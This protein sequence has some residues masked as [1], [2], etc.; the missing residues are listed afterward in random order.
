MVCISLVRKYHNFLVQIVAQC[1]E[2]NEK[3]LRFQFFE[4][5]L[6]LFTIFNQIFGHFLWASQKTRNVLNQIFVFFSFFVRFRGCAGRSL[7]PIFFY[8]SECI[9]GVKYKI[10]HISKAKNRTKK[11]QEY[12]NSDQN[13][14]HLLI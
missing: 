9:T 5:L 10:D 6:I 13:I 12:N 11:T 4:L 14:V 7:P 3:K 1:S 8:I 2:T